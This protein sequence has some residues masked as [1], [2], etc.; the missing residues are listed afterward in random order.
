MTK[1][2][3]IMDFH[4]N[5]MITKKTHHLDCLM[6]I[7]GKLVGDLVGLHLNLSHYE[8]RESAVNT[9]A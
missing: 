8:T 2:N 5:I 9:F 6:L 3:P 4:S 7:L 1:E